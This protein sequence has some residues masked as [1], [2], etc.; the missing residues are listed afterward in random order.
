MSNVIRLKRSSVTSVVPAPSS[1]VDGELAL[2]LA[3]RKLF[4][5]DSGGAVFEIG[6]SA[7]AFLDSPAFTGVPTA[8]TAAP[9]TNTDQLSTTAFVKAAVNAAIAGLDFQKDILDVQADATLDPSA[10]P[11]MGDR[12]IVTDVTALHAH[13]GTIAGV[14]NNDIIEFNGT[15]FV[16]EYDVSVAGEGALVWNR[17]LDSWFR[18]DGIVWDE[19]GGLAGVIG[20]VGISVSGSTISIDLAELTDLGTGAEVDDFV[21]LTDTSATGASMKVSVQNLVANVELDGGVYA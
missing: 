4:A 1:L 2:N 20:G 13:F 3:D 18:W 6:G 5:K 21:A 10:A 19:F 16:V 7:Y 12:Y 11:I 15:E 9:G 14:A 8:P 17:A